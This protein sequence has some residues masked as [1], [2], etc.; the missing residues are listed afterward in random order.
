MAASILLFISDSPS[1][2]YGE[3]WDW[4]ELTATDQAINEAVSL[5]NSDDAVRT[6]PSA[7]EPLAE[8]AWLHVLDTTQQPQILSAVYQVRAVLIV[9]DD[10]PP[11]PDDDRLLQRQSFDAGMR[12]QG[13]ELIFSDV[14]DGVLLY[15]RP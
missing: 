11:L 1:S 6:T 13:Y 15:Y 10:L 4:S 3:P 7:L 14:N 2:P 8:R 5:L 9:E 12:T